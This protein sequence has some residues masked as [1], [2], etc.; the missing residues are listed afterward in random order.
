MNKIR[1]DMSY[2][3]IMDNNVSQYDNSHPYAPNQTYTNTLDTYLNIMENQN[4]QQKYQYIICNDNFK[5]VNTLSHFLKILGI[6]TNNQNY[7]KYKLSQNNNI[8]KFQKHINI[9]ERWFML[10]IEPPYNPSDTEWIEHENFKLK[11]LRSFYCSNDPIILS[12]LTKPD[13]KYINLL[14][15]VISEKTIQYTSF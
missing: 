5:D 2:I 13:N 7:L 14:S 8:L 11:N 4:I 10:F 3:V 12:N 9:L 15:S 6:Y 1:N